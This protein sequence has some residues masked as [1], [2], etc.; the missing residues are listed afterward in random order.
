MEFLIGAIIGLGALM[1]LRA[2]VDPTP[3]NSRPIDWQR[4]QTR[5]LP[6]IAGALA[7][8][9]AAYAFTGSAPIAL[10]LALLGAV[11]PAAWKNAAER[12]RREALREAWPE[13]LDEVVSGVRAGLS[14][15]ESLSQL[16]IRGPEIVRPAF[17]DFALH[18][19][20]AGRLNPC[21]DELKNRLSDPMADRIVE[22]MRI[23]NDLGGRDLAAMLSDLAKLVREDNRARGD[24]LARQ[25]WT[26]NG[27][28][29]AAVAPWLM[30]LLFTSRPG[31]FE[32]F[33]TPAGIAVLAL[34]LVMT[35][36]AYALMIRLGRL[37]EESRIF[38][39][40]QSASVDIAQREAVGHA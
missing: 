21:L 38:G 17:A 35:I 25:S 29:L 27:A 28:R 20:A 4:A 33:A 5:L 13:V 3:Q 10:C 26:V 11:L 14:V 36:A 1:I 30:L 39:K 6:P 34:G 7:T 24:L 23:S 2:A 16:A 15:G 37:P 22:A 12:R 19:R 18:L 31:T 32:A 8:F 9:V 40:P